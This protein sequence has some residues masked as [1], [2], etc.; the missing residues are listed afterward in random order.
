MKNFFSK[1]ILFLT[2]LIIPPSMFVIFFETYS[3]FRKRMHSLYIHG[4][5]ITIERI[6]N[7]EQQKIIFIG[8]SN[9][10]FGISSKMIEDSLGIKT[11]NMGVHGGIG[12]KKWIDDISKY[13][14]SNDI[15][16]FSP[17]YNCFDLNSYQPQKNYVQFIN[18]FGV[19]EI[20]SLRAFYHYL[21]HISRK[22]FY[23]S[24]PLELKYDINWFN[25]NGDVIGH[26]NEPMKYKLITEFGGEN[27]EIRVLKNLKSYIE[28][29]LG[30]I[31]YFIIPP[32]THELRF[33]LEE[34]IEL[35]NN[36]Q[37]I[38]KEKYPLSINSST[39]KS[40]CFYDTQYHL[41]YHCAK[42]RTK[43]ILD[44]LKTEFIDRRNHSNK[45]IN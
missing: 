11:F 8:G 23:S 9:V 6:N 38:F 36:L 12:I 21:D 44:F 22:I 18:N 7:Y 43:M 35:N 33:T 14:K 30:G 29:K 19:L 37:K 27:L 3:E 25:E 10:G 41:N 15:V 2:L 1:I 39:F 45:N 40:K 34:E 42:K 16:I 5:N 28:S 32:A 31:S 13:L 4:Y 26:Y 20:R 17:E 24:N